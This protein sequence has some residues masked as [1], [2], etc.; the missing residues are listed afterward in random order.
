MSYRTYR[1]DTPPALTVVPG[2]AKEKE[3]VEQDLFTRGSLFFS[4]LDESKRSTNRDPVKET[5]CSH[6][7]GQT[8]PK[9]DLNLVLFFLRANLNPA[10][11]Q[12]CLE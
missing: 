7:R 3:A 5:K 2:Y 6:F 10:K 4:R 12:V 11:R 9:R 1:R 8:Y